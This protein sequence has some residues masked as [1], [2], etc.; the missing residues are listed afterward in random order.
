MSR[1]IRPPCSSVAFSREMCGTPRV[2]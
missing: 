2:A 1:D